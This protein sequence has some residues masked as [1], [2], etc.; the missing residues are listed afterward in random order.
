MSDH[1]H[2]DQD[3]DHCHTVNNG[4]VLPASET[5][6]RMQVACVQF[7]EELSPEQRQKAILPFDANDRFRWHYVPVE[8]FPRQGLS[9]KEMQIKQQ[10]KAFSLLAASLSKK[11]YQKA[12]AII[13][14]ETILGEIEQS[15]GTGKFARDPEQYYFTIFGDPTNKQPWGWRV[16]GH[17]VSLHYTI[18]NKQLISPVPSFFG[19]NPGEVKDG[20]H[21]GLRILSE[22]EDLARELLKTLSHDQKSKAIL[23]V[24]APHD[25]LT[26]EQ[27]KV[28]IQQAQGLAMESMNPSQREVLI[29]LIHEY[30]DRM[31][32]QVAQ[33][34]LQKLRHAD[35]NQIHFAWAGGEERG[36]PHYYRLHGQTFFAE[37]DNVQNNANHIHSIWRHLEDDFGVDLLRQ[38]YHNKHH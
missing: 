7:L 19:A 23:N 37:Y 36:Q 26:R 29:T 35:L 8:M 2:G 13:D 11:G 17:H 28:E 21:K 14:L 4:L 27:P 31:P 9:I 34:E 15:T 6:E 16:E 3:S 33:N 1:H 10:E 32:N 25:I 30:I 20:K 38:H 22:E 5:S 18:I 12:R 24:E